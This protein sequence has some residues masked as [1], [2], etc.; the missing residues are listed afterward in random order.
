V[1]VCVCV[2]GG[3]LP[4][5]IHPWQLRANRTMNRLMLPPDAYNST[6]A[7]PVKVFVVIDKLGN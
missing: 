7:D 1:C 4:F 3:L 6:I 2:C 5:I